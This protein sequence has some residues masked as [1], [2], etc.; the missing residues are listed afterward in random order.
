MRGEKLKKQLKVDINPQILKECLYHSSYLNEIRRG[1]QHFELQKAHIHI[2]ML[3]YHLVLASLIA[4][5][6]TTNHKVL[7]EKLV[8]YKDEILV[9]FYDENQLNEFLYIGKGELN[10]RK[11]RYLEH[12]YILFYQIYNQVGFKGLGKIISP[13]YKS[14]KKVE[15]QIDYKSALQEYIQQ[16]KL[17]QDTIIYETLKEEGLQH[18][19]QFTVK[20]T[21]NGFHG[22]GTANSKKKA[23]QKAAQ[24]WFENSMVSILKEKNKPVQ[25][26]KKQ[27]LVMTKNRETELRQVYK[28]LKLST[29]DIALKEFDICFTHK[30]FANEKKLNTMDRPSFF[31][32]IGA[33]VLP[34]LIGEYILGDFQERANGKYSRLMEL[35][36][37]LV[38]KKHLS[39]CLPES[40]YHSFRIPKKSD[41]SAPAL[42][43]DFVQ[44]LIGAMFIH[45]LFQQKKELFKNTTAFIQD[46]IISTFG[47]TS[48]SVDYRSHLQILTQALGMQVTAKLVTTGPSHQSEHEVEVSTFFQNGGKHL[49]GTGKASAKK[50]GVNL[51]CREIIQKMNTLYH[52][53][54]QNLELPNK[55]LWND[56][57]AQLIYCAVNNRNSQKFLEALGGLCLQ[58]WSLE[59]AMNIVTHLYRRDL[60]SELIMLL[61]KWEILYSREMVEKCITPLPDDAKVVIRNK[62]QEANKKREQWKTEHLV[63]EN[64]GE[65]DFFLLLEELEFKPIKNQNS[66]IGKIGIIEPQVGDE[67][68][69]DD[70]ISDMLDFVPIPE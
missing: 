8:Q 4:K 67:F 57:L 45:N 37:S 5:E 22:V 70:G 26:A 1:S 55:P 65:D 48:T 21:A 50:Q 68:E 60:K 13:L 15:K 49:V 43:A 32:W 38:S 58:L 59:N 61:M 40:I 18:E 27:N 47:E 9:R 52:L 2:G 16:L 10:Y 34:F 29:N 24:N 7:A 39:S 35:T 28:K 62:W 63:N 11:D 20:V 17:N 53:N 51:A 12:G 69:D 54:H 56:T 41:L 36:G 14:S 19:R 6:E 23:Q 64:D 46:F 33:I 3:I 42:R 25:H 66:I 44:S 31:A 30:S